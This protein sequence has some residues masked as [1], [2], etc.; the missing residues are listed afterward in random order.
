M[1][2]WQ[3]VAQT[4]TTLTWGRT[5]VFSVQCSGDEPLEPKISSLGTKLTQGIRCTPFLGKLRKVTQGASYCNFSQNSDY[6]T[7]LPLISWD[8]RSWEP[9]SLGVRLLRPS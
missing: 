8:S 2:C 9:T 7:E 4:T 6:S 3:Q 1:L 5:R